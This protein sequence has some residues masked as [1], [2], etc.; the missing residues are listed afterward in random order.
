VTEAGEEEAPLAEAAHPH[1]VAE[2]K[3]RRPSRAPRRLLLAVAAVVP[4]HPLAAEVVELPL[5][6]S[7]AAEE[8]VVAEGAATGVPSLRPLRVVAEAVTSAAATVAA[9]RRLLQLPDWLPNHLAVV[10]AV[11]PPT[12]H[13]PAAAMVAATAD[14]QVR[15]HPLLHR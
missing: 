5:R 7:P 14:R 12:R 9:I 4:L 11:V 3:V 8:A 10:G 1:P 13:S 6:R 15:Q 2:A